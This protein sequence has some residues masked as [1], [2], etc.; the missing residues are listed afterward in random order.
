MYSPQSPD[1]ADAFSHEIEERPNDSL[2]TLKLDYL[3]ALGIP[4][5][6]AWP[7]D[8]SVS[9]LSLQLQRRSANTAQVQLPTHV[10]GVSEVDWQAT[11]PCLSR[12][13]CLLG[14]PFLQEHDERTTLRML[15]DIAVSSLDAGS[16]FQLNFGLRRVGYITV[17]PRI[18]N[19]NDWI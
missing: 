15:T 12:T 11:L 5:P 19:N 13:H 10:V 18:I 7:P 8:T 2:N 1:H 6:P 17:L 3:C 9:Q 16:P 14:T 4:H